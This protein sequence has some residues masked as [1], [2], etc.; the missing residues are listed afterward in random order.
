MEKKNQKVI[1]IKL[2]FLLRY[3]RYCYSFAVGTTI[4][5]SKP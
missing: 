3:Y 2:E 1:P 5:T 4:K